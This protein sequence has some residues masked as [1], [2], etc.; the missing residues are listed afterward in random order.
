M[1]SGI[2]S[3]VEKVLLEL[4]VQYLVETVHRILLVVGKTHLE[5]LLDWQHPFRTFHHRVHQ[6]A[7][8]C[9]TLKDVG[10]NY[11]LVAVVV[12]VAVAAAG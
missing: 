11:Y 1:G 3:L 12:A 9:S 7:L 8:N 2:P 6:V 4:A 10:E 5:R